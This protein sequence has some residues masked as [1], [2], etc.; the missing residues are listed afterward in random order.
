MADPRFH[1]GGLFAELSR[2]KVIRVAVTYGLV[3]F[4]VIEA[5][6]I[7][8]D[9]INLPPQFVVFVIVTIFLGFP[10]AIVLVTKIKPTASKE[11]RN[12]RTGNKTGKQR[13]SVH[14]GLTS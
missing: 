14:N 4:A 1:I 3:G 9:A 7:I 6:D 2:R 12:K 10:I 8:V 11:N 5:A 13:S